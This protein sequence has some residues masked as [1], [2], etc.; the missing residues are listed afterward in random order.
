[1]AFYPDRTNALVS[2][3]PNSPVTIF[4]NHSVGLISPTWP[5][6]IRDRDSFSCSPCNPYM[7]TSVVQFVGWY[8]DW[9]TISSLPDLCS[10]D[11]VEQGASL[12]V[13][14]HNLISWSDSR[15]LPPLFIFCFQTAKLSSDVYHWCPIRIV[16]SD[17]NLIYCAV[18]VLHFLHSVFR[19]IKFPQSHQLLS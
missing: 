12:W 5:Y 11:W 9:L 2:T 13:P 7:V 15:T 18:P 17:W 10:N 3:T 8:S 19:R 1:M 4:V 6:H 16:T 14:F